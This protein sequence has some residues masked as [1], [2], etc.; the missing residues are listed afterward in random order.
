MKRI[1]LLFSAGLVC[2]FT[3]FGCNGDDAATTMN[4][5]E[6]GGDG[7]GDGD[8]GD[9]DGD[10]NGDGDGD[11]NGDG[12]GDTNG[13]GDGDPADCTPVEVSEDIAT[14][15][16]WTADNCYFLSDIVFVNGATLTIEP[17]TLVRGLSGSALVVEK[18][19][20]LVAVGTADAPIVFTSNETSPAAGDWG[21]IVLIGDATANIGVGMAEGFA[22]PPTYGG[23]DDAHNCGTLQYL[24]VEYAGF[25]ISEGN[26]LNGITFYACGSGTTVD[27][28]QVH[29]GFDDGIEW[30]G[31]GFDADHIVVTGASDDSLDIDQGFHGTIQHVFVHQ[32]PAVGDNC[33]EVSNQGTDFDAVPKTEPEICNATCVGSGMGGEKSKGITIKEATHGSWY[34]NIFTNTTNA[35]TTLLDDPQA[36]EVMAGNIEIA[37]NIFSGNLGAP[38][39]DSKSVVIDTA[40]W[41][42]W[43]EDPA[44]ANLSSDPG[45]GSVDW[46]SPD[47]TPSGDVSGDGSGCGGTTYIGAIDP[48]GTNWT[49]EGWINYVP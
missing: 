39:H 25:A 10:T 9:G 42:M 13:D 22:I 11:T 19:S 28:V 18:D 47:A 24:R 36:A 43:V 30:F 38:E 46:G 8:S 37:N 20:M 21:G 31:G 15:T 17:G 4:A 6:T 41:T 32:N 23:D 26:E 7:D 29:M 27:H 12:D 34:A 44:R 2:S 5:E 35:A 33:F 49:A 16:T 48:A 1:P 14:D 45:L 3:L 40:A